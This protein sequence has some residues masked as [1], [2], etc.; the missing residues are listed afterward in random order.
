MVIEER[1]ACCGRPMLSKGLINDARRAARKNVD[2][3][4]PYA[5]AG[6]PGY[7][8]VEEWRLSAYTLRRGAYVPAELAD[9]VPFPVTIDPEDLAP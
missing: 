7:L 6:I 8:R 9:V 2:V 5:E 4:A 3:L 1:R